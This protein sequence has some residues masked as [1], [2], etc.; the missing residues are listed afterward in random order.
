MI[1]GVKVEFIKEAQSPEYNPDTGMTE[2][3]KKVIA[4]KTCRVYDLSTRRT[5]ELFG[6]LDVRG[7]TLY[8]LGRRVKGANLA[9]INGTVYR[10]EA[11]RDLPVA[12]PR[13]ATYVLTESKTE[14]ESS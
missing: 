7:L 2:R 8:H 5:V 12:H 3:P 13:K 6:A 14:T 1:S 4:T 10:I 9:R 11:S